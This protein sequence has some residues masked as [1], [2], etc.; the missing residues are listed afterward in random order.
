MRT[1]L[2]FG[3]GEVLFS[4]AFRITPHDVAAWERAKVLGGRDDRPGFRSRLER[5]LVAG[6]PVPQDLMLACALEALEHASG[7]DGCMLQPTSA[8]KLR[9]LAPV[10]I[11]E[12]LSSVATV[13]YRSDRPEGS[14]LTLSIEIR[15][16]G[17]KLA[18]VEL[19]VEVTAPKP[20]A[21]AAA[22][23]TLEWPHAPFNQAA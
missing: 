13:R 16:G 21:N 2:S 8:G 7:L 9:S 17:R 3:V 18:D 15:G 12:P 11:G 20:T 14:F 4:S 5:P 19:C 23:A 10:G 22:P 1:P 6:S